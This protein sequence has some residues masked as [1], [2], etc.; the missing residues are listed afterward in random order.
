MMLSV[1]KNAK[2][3][4]RSYNIG[5]MHRVLDALYEMGRSR[6]TDIAVYSGL[7]N[8]MA[9]RY[10]SLMNLFRWIEIEKEEGHNVI[11]LT[12]TGIFIHNQLHDTM[13]D[14]GST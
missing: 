6:P 4:S 9:K 7:N 14:E 5:V 1:N 2:K 11:C 12:E 8:Q 10:L 3:I 13:P